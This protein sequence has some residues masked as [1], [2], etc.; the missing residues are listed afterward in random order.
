[1]RSFLIVLS[2]LDVGG[3]QRFCLN[4]CKYFNSQ[5]Y[6]YMVLFLRKGKSEKL[7][8]EFID[9]NIFFTELNC[10]SVMRSIPK[11]IQ[12][13]NATKPDVI[14]STVGNVD[15]AMSIAKLF[16]PNSRLFI[17]KANVVFDNQNNVINRMK[18]RL[19]S[20]VSDKLVALTEDMK[21]DF[22]QYGFKEKNIVVINNMV[23][24]KYI[25]SR[26]KE[27][28]IKHK[29]FDKNRYKLIVANARMVP[30]KR[31]D[32]LISAFKILSEKIPEAR[33]IILGDGP[34][35]K[36]IENS[37]PS[38]MMNKVDFLGFQNNPYYYMRHASVFVLT[39]DYEGFPNVVIEALA[40]G[41][42]VIATN[43]KTGPREIIENSVDGWV[44]TKGDYNAVAEGLE[45]VLM[46]PAAE[47]NQLSLNAKRKARFYS[48]DVIAQ[49]YLQV[50]NTDTEN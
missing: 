14:L 49:Q 13:A 29:W 21:L 48:S 19:E 5:K 35:R 22:L 43:C 28:G 26:C 36:Q 3:A 15:F 2:A 6:E 34:L 23:D 44:V 41:V 20:K 45:S 11:V 47:W 38:E 25:E 18:L 1:M 4:I 30:E 12:Y 7:R 39:S 40:C 37:I 16:I 24:L 9:N 17:R 8:Q 27:P 32:V 46:K 50:I 42:P 31:Y 33:L 10:K